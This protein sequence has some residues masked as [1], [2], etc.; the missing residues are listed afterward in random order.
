MKTE[1][2]FLNA[3]WVF[4]LGTVLVNGWFHLFEGYE[5]DFRYAAVGI[6]LLIVCEVVYRVHRGSRRRPKV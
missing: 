3:I 1:R 4:V 2:I 5:R 6:G